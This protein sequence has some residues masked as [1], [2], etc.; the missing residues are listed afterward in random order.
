MIK[1][2]IYFT[3]ARR[4]VILD[5]GKPIVLTDVVIPACTDLASLSIDVW[6]Q[7]EEVDGQRF[8]VATDI[9]VKSLIMN[10]I[11]PTL[12]CR[13]LKVFITHLF[14]YKCNQNQKKKKDVIGKI[15][16]NRLP[17]V[18]STRTIYKYTA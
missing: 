6:V 8:V 7:G 4:F 2:P 1:I 18:I 11:I 17:L 5:F 15:A 10:D 16:I 12:V 14:K 13:Y 9:G 3:G